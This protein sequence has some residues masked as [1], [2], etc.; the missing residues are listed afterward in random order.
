[1]NTDDYEG[2]TEGPWHYHFFDGV[3]EKYHSVTWGGEFGIQLPVGH[4][5]DVKLIAAAPDL[6]KEVKRLRGEPEVNKCPTCGSSDI[7]IYDS[8]VDSGS[9]KV[10]CEGDGCESRWFEIWR[11]VGIEMIEGED[12][13]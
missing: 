1:M 4:S 8:F 12:N 10:R 11:H 3:D 6:L 13:R 2:H 9:H 7:T 5:A